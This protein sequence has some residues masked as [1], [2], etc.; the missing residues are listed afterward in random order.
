MISNANHDVYTHADRG[1]SSFIRKGPIAS[2]VKKI[3][4]RLCMSSLVLGSMKL[5][6]TI[7]TYLSNVN[8]TLNFGFTVGIHLKL[9]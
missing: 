9:C 5:N 7:S 2:Q 3:I 8:T 1:D 6:T 4:L